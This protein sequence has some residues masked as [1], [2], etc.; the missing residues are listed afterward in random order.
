M[1]T[2]VSPSQ[3]SNFPPILAHA[4]TSF[5]KPIFEFPAKFQFG[6]GARIAKIRISR[7]NQIAARDRHKLPALDNGAGRHAFSG[8][9][10]FSLRRCPVGL[11]RPGGN[12]PNPP[13]YSAHISDMGQFRIWTLD[14]VCI[15]SFHYTTAHTVT[16]P[17]L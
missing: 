14:S 17:D 1:R 5:I 16:K 4:Q 9:G 3:Y 13:K 6:S 7:Q 2:Q 8:W 15:K 10:F 11:R 12:P